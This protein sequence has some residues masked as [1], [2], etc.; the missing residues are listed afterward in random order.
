L[1][2]NLNYKLTLFVHNK[3]IHLQQQLQTELQNLELMAKEPNRA[4]ELH[5]WQSTA[6]LVVTQK[7]TLLP[8]FR[9]AK[10]IL[11]TRGV[12][13]LVR[14]TGGSAVLQSKA[15][16]NV[17]LIWREQKGTSIADAYQHMCQPLRNTLLKYGVETQLSSVKGAFCDGS[18]NLV[19]DGLKLAGTSQR[20]K[21]TPQGLAVLGHIVLI[22]SK[23][24]ENELELVDDFYGLAGGE[25]VLKDHTLVGLNELIPQFQHQSTHFQHGFIKSLAREYSGD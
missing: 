1:K 15:V 7:D 22:L 10:D 12:D 8:N 11:A 20:W 17:S 4:P 24:Y 5:V 14:K 23:S 2:A 3:P 6:A 16:V 21:R 25:Q 9:V 18:Y 13:V 19:V